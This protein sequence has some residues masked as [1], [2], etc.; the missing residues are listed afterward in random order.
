MMSNDD[1]HCKV[2]DYGT[3]DFLLVTVVIACFISLVFGFYIA[4]IWPLKITKKLRG[5]LAS[6]LDVKLKYREEINSKSN[7]VGGEQTEK[8]SIHFIE[9]VLDNGYQYVSEKAK[10]ALLSILGIPHNHQE[11]SGQASHSWSLM[12]S[13]CSAQLWTCMS[14]GDGDGILL[15]TSIFVKKKPEDVLTWLMEENYGTGLENVFDN[16]VIESHNDASIVLKRI[17][18]DS[19]SFTAANRDFIV[20]TSTSLQLDGSFII[21]SRSTNIH[22]IQLRNCDGHKRGIIHA[23]GFVL[24]PVESSKG[25][26]CEVIYGIHIDMLGTAI[27]NLKLKELCKSTEML[28]GK[29]ETYCSGTTVEMVEDIRHNIIRKNKSVLKPESFPNL[30]TFHPNMIDDLIAIK[31]SEEV[32]VFRDGSIDFTTSQICRIG[33]SSNNAITQMRNLHESLVSSQHVEEIPN[34]INLD[35]RVSKFSPRT[36]EGSIPDYNLRQR[37]D[38]TSGGSVSGGSWSQ[39]SSPVATPKSFLPVIRYD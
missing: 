38:D 35:L 19:G 4:R 8:S 10:N 24:R 14:K 18:C 2:N 27:N 12:S 21:A 28:M 15:K 6:K 36:S 37:R 34:Q 29:I 30:S 3:Q 9:S 31:K 16:V 11:E 1:S 26:G 5:I 39:S 23:C 33:I 7:D 22:N 20:V 17:S 25:T 32:T 13:V